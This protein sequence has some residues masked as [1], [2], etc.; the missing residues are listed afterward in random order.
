MTEDA[1]GLDEP[2]FGWPSAAQLLEAAADSLDRLTTLGDDAV[3]RELRVVTHVVRLVQRELELGAE[4]AAAHSSRLA[5][6]GVAGDRELADLIRSATA[7]VLEQIRAPLREE[8]VGRV[9]IANPR[10][11]QPMPHRNLER[12]FGPAAEPPPLEDT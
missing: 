1:T 2:P 7:P 11:L 3:R 8:T 10:W 6:L 5:S 12:L 9:R 4:L